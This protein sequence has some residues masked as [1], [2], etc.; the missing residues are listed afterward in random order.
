MLTLTV[1]LVLASFICAVASLAGKMHPAVAI[2]LLVVLEAV[3]IFPV[4]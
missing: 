2:L 4:R 3:R 1:L